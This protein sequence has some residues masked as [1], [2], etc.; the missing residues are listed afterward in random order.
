[1]AFG[2]ERTVRARVNDVDSG[3]CARS[4][5]GVVEPYESEDNHSN[6]SSSGGG[7]PQQPRED[8][9]SDHG[10]C[11]HP[12]ARALC[13]GFDSMSCARIGHALTTQGV[14]GSFEDSMGVVLGQIVA[15]EVDLVVVSD[16]VPLHEVLPVSE[17]IRR[18]SPAVKIVIAGDAP[19]SG[20]LL[21]AV[22]GGVV[23]WIDLG[24]D[25]DDMC[26]RIA[27]ALEL[28]REERR[29][30]ERVSRLKGICQRLGETRGEFV[31]QMDSLG[32]DLAHAAEEMRGRVDEAA[33]A[34]EFRGLISQELDVEDLL[35]TSMQ[36]L[37]T[38][39][40]PTNAAVFLPGS[41]S[42]QF[43]LGAYVHYDCPR[44]SAQPFLQ[45]LCDDV[46]PRLAATDDIVRYA[47][48]E[49]F[50]QALGIEASVLEDSELVAW[51]ALHDGECMGVFFLFRNR[52]EPFRDELAGLIDALRPVFA[53][54]MAKLVRVHHRSN[55]QWP[56]QR[57]ES[58]DDVTDDDSDEG[59]EGESWRRAA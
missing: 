34:G 14:D 3:A 53:A 5:R 49:E 23:D 11:D 9:R 17:R 46:C 7:N 30:D 44:A 50:V 24:A 16:R 20:M 40:G 15:S 56:A 18:I 51:P 8:D 48:T 38:K 2:I 4:R 35:R 29:R 25:D 43:G 42:N 36:Y 41:K 26:A 27:A 19:R 59:D 21:R 31:R 39:T 57:A 33:M 6:G 1:M 13:V 45:R 22:R 37:L 52:S 32:A 10:A 58:A 55:F 54:Q 28:G 47:D 12:H